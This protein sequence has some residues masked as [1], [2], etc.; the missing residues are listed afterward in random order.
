M[1]INTSSEWLTVMGMATAVML[2]APIVWCVSLVMMVF[3]LLKAIVTWDA[4]HI[5]EDFE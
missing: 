5:S 1:L 2:A 4:I 3:Y